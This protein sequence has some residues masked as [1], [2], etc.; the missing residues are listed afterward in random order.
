MGGSSV[1]IGLIGISLAVL[2][3]LQVKLDP[4]AITERLPFLYNFSLNKWYFD[5]LYDR[6]FIRGTRLVA[7][8]ALEVDQRIVDGIVNFAGLMTMLSGEVLKYVETGKAQFYALV[9]FASAIVIVV[10]SGF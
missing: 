9:L 1:G 5:E 10:L 7:R 2:F 6:V 4:R 3:Y 8:E